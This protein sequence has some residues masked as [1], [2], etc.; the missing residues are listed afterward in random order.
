M[1]PPSQRRGSVRTTRVRVQLHRYVIYPYTQTPSLHINQLSRREAVQNSGAP[2]EDYGCVYHIFISTPTLIMPLALDYLHQFIILANSVIYSV[3]TIVFLV[4]YP[5]PHQ[6]DT[7]TRVHIV[8]IP[9]MRWK[10]FR[11]A[12]ALV[13]HATYKTNNGLFTASIFTGRRGHKE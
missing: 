10:R 3:I 12:Y 4:C 1:G 5:Q 9:R 11:F 7:R 8:H 6:L 2:S 13:Y